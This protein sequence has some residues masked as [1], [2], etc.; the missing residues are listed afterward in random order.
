VH[1]LALDGEAHHLSLQG[2]T[3][4]AISQTWLSKLLGEMAA[5]VAAMAHYNCGKRPDI[6]WSAAAV[7]APDAELP[8]G[9]A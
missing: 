2:N 5:A 7:V 4:K 6:N 8:L 1:R 9:W 3:L